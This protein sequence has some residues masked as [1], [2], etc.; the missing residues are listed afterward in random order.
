MA[1]LSS[2]PILPA[3]PTQD[4]KCQ[5]AGC[6]RMPNFNFP[7]EK[8]GIFCA[9]HKADGMVDIKHKRCVEPGCTKRP[10]FNYS[11]AQPA[12]EVCKTRISQSDRCGL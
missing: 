4:R 7:G 9:Q 11:G 6:S 3:C 5:G 2:H 12:Q 1:T 8:G 10:S